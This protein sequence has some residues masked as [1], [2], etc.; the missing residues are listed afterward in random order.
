MRFFSP[1]REQNKKIALS[2]HFFPFSCLLIK[3]E[4]IPL[5]LKN[6]YLKKVLLLITIRK[7]T[8]SRWDNVTSW[9]F[10]RCRPYAEAGR[11]SDG[12][13]ICFGVQASGG[14]NKNRKCRKME[15]YCVYGFIVVLISILL[16]T[17]VCLFQTLWKTRLSQTR[18]D[19]RL[20]TLHPGDKVR[21]LWDDE[22]E[23]TVKSVKKNSI[24]CFSSVF[25]GVKEYGKNV[26]AVV[27]WWPQKGK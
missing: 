24:L 2:L 17:D 5:C 8:K 6:D 11:K 21:C 19:V 3:K 22:H 1:F 26:L 25:D 18:Y 13:S 7:T 16:Y 9:C 27:E 23:M 4:S 15:A 14:G 12:A 10:L 20:D